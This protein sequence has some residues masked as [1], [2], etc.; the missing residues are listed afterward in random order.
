MSGKVLVPPLPVATTAVT[1][2]LTTLP[3]P[4]DPDT[5][6]VAVVVMVLT[7]LPVLHVPQLP[8]CV[9]VQEL[10][11]PCAVAQVDQSLQHGPRPLPHG[12][13]PPGPP[14]QDDGQADQGTPSEPKFPGLPWPPDPQGP[15]FQ[16]D[17]APGR[18]VEM[19]VT[20]GPQEPVMVPPDVAEMV[21]S[22]EGKAERVVPALTQIWATAE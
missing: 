8:V 20:K 7:T 12:P 14:T 17:G 16:P 19:P 10:V 2:E 4:P 6:A 1:A 5:D 11:K 21:A 9:H 13:Q 18:A 15:P 22:W 3:L